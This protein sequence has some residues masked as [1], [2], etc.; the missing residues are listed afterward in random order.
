MQHERLLRYVEQTIDKRL[1]DNAAR[2]SAILEQAER[3][4]KQAPSQAPC[5]TRSTDVDIDAFS[6]EL[7][8]A[9]QFSASRLDED[10][11]AYQTRL[12][13]Y[14]T[15]V[16]N[17]KHDKRK[18]DMS[19][20]LRL[21]RVNSMDSRSRARNVLAIAE[22]YNET[23]LKVADTVEMASCLLRSS[24]GSDEGLSSALS[25]LVTDYRRMLYIVQR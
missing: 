24:A 7:Q 6:A 3:V 25:D 5:T 1:A 15:Y 4:V 14:E 20:A 12:R 22:S 11:R 10:R 13:E 2:A 18:T 21:Q 19:Y 16:P 23:I 9:V 17:D 8:A